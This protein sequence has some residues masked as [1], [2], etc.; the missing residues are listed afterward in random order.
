MPTKHSWQWSHFQCGFDSASAKA[1]P[2]TLVEEAD[3]PQEKEEE[4]EEEQ[5]VEEE[6]EEQKGEGEGDEDATDTGRSIR[7][8][9]FFF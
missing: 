4:D 6:E 2:W 3:E 1:I 8:G 7:D 5:E 9:I